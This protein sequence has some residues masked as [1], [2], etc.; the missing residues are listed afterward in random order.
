MRES[1]VILPISALAAISRGNLLPG[2]NMSDKRYSEKILRGVDK[3]G[4]VR[5]QSKYGIW[6]DEKDAQHIWGVRIL[7]LYPNSR[8][9]SID[10]VVL[11]HAVAD[12][13]MDQNTSLPSP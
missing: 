4:R 5:P 10:Q 3:M 8:G 9:K 12:N 11:A 6:A 13:V 7:V 1:V 2:E